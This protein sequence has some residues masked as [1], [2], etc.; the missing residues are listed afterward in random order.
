MLVL[1]VCVTVYD[2]KF[3]PKVSGQ[4]SAT[5]Y[6]IAQIWQR[7]VNDQD[8][9]IIKQ[10]EFVYLYRVMGT[11]WRN[12]EV[13]FWPRCVHLTLLCMCVCVCMYVCMCL[14]VYMFVCVWLVPLRIDASSSSATA[15]NETEVGKQKAIPRDDVILG[16]NEIWADITEEYHFANV[17]NPTKVPINREQCNLEIFFRTFCHGHS[18][19][20]YEGLFRILEVRHSFFL[21]LVLTAT[22]NVFPIDIVTLPPEHTQQQQQQQQQ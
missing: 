2:P 18:A 13:Q 19:T 17:P 4:V 14:C 15:Y 6:D 7:F 8:E 21:F 5:N 1:G 16:I 9:Y 22:N 11:L 3:N 10:A 20:N 12:D